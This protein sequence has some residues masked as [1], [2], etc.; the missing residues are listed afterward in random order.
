ML[1]KTKEGLNVLTDTVGA[2]CEEHK[3]TAFHKVV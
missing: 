1:P 3:A 2:I